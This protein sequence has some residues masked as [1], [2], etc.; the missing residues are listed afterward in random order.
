MDLILLEDKTPKP[1]PNTAILKAFI[2]GCDPTANDKQKGKK[3]FD[4]VFDLGGKD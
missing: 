1:Y 3:P 4:Y 2:L